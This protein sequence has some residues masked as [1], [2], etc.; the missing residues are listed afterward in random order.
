[1]TNRIEEYRTTKELHD[2]LRN[3]EEY[4]ESVL[5]PGIAELRDN[6][7]K[8]KEDIDIWNIFDD[9][10]IPHVY[11]KSLY[12]IIK[13]L[14]QKSSYKD[15]VNCFKNL[16]YGKNIKPLTEARYSNTEW[17]KDN[18]LKC[19]TYLKN[20]KE[21]HNVGKTASIE[22]QPIFYYYASVYLFSFLL[23]SFVYFD[24]SKKHHGIYVK[25]M[26]DI[27]NIEFEYARHGFFERLV[28]VL[29]ILNYPSSFSSFL[30]DF[31]I[32]GHTIISEH[33]TD[34]S[35]INNTELT[36][37]KLVQHDF[38]RDEK[39]INLL[40]RVEKLN[41]RYI[42]TSNILKDFILIF[43][44]CN[45]ARYDPS[46]WKRI[47]LGEENDLIFHFKRAFQNINNMVRFVNEIFIEAENARFPGHQ[48]SLVFFK[49]PIL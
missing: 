36:L 12:K 24:N 9:K 26:H 34:L 22:T 18:I 21:F 13:N 37:K 2:D 40:W 16:N 30:T 4:A 1:M 39:N 25:N 27:H 48:Q 47:Y 15:R 20:A 17:R 43:I 31:N 3:I 38:K 32:S 46:S 19:T 49:K 8:L 45:V 33:Q 41:E 6:L 14:N 42:K 23:D 5:S 11:E 44:S 10:I 7:L 28:H 29:T 35:I